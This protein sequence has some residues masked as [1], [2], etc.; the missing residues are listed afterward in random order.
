MW[1]SLVRRLFEPNE[2]SARYTV[3]RATPKR[4]A[5]SA[6]GISAVLSNARMVL[7]SFGGEFGWGA[8][9]STARTRR[10]QANRLGSP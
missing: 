4:A 2:D 7:I 8:A 3:D 5:I 9:L 6:T 1:T 10:F